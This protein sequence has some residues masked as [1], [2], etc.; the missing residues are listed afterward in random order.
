MLIGCPLLQVAV[1]H[2]EVWLS[3]CFPCLFLWS[4]AETI[5][6]Y[7]QVAVAHAVGQRVGA[8]HADAAYDIANVLIRVCPRLYVQLLS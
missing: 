4:H 7:F 1:A 8:G 6:P 5:P 2:H 3:F